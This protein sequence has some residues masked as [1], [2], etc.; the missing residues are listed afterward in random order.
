ME[1]IIDKRSGFCFGVE[2]AIVMAE[3][4]AKS[5]NPLYCL[6]EI[7]HN[8]E[9]VKRLRKQGIEFITREIF[10]TLKDCNVLIR[11][12]G[13]PP[14]TYDYAASNNLN[15]IDATCPVVL[16][17][18]DKVRSVVQNK[19]DGQVVIYGK[20]DHPE[21]IGL[22]GQVSSAIVVESVE[23]L[24]MVNLDRPIFLFAQT[25][26]ERAK[27]ESIKQELLTRLKDSGNPESHLVISNSICGL[28]ANRAPWLAEFSRTV[29]AMIFVGD[30]SSSNSRVLFDVCKT[31]NSNSYFISCKEDLVPENIKGSQKIGIS[32]A[33][34]TPSWLINDIAT[35]LKSIFQNTY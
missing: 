6:G 7:V 31:N 27:F 26:K 5:F 1:I 14:E 3:K 9:E 10:F 24:S 21:V 16:R 32:G 29:D 28:V 22:I 11:A 35:H 18:Q 13:E 23:E 19:R 20:K 33:T 30:K 12:H 15:L 2:R 34:S 17:L 25:T 8:L 4:A